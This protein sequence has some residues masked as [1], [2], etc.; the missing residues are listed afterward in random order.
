ML[1]EWE[2]GA[3]H[4]FFLSPPCKKNA[5]HNSADRPVVPPSTRQA[6]GLAILLR[7]QYWYASHC[8]MK[9]RVQWHRSIQ[10]ITSMYIDTR[11]SRVPILTPS[12]S[13]S[14]PLLRFALYLCCPCPVTRGRTIKQIARNLRQVESFQERQADSARGHGV[15]RQFPLPVSPCDLYAG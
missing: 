8:A 10:F 11:Q 15:Q 1:S 14:E 9:V 4:R 5:L 2:R 12:Q 7:H 3:C 6:S 13:I